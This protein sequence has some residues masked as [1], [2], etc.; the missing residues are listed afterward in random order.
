[1]RCLKHLS[2]RFRCFINRSIIVSTAYWWCIACSPPTF[3]QEYT[4]CYEK[5]EQGDAAKD[6]AC[7]ST[8]G[9]FVGG[10]RAAS[11]GTGGG[12]VGGGGGGGV[13][14]DDVLRGGGGGG[15]WV[16]GAE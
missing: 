3:H 12:S 14:G 15:A 6:A 10:I 4:K 1:I 2:T 8:Y 16:A 5:Q 7:N 11:K 13:H 9:R